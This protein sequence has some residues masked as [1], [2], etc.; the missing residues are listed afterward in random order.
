M[1]EWAGPLPR[2]KLVPK[3]VR[4]GAFWRFFKG[5]KHGQKHR[6]TD[7]MVQSLNAAYKSSAKIIQKI[8]GQTRERSHVASCLRHCTR[9]WHSQAKFQGHSITWRNYEVWGRIPLDNITT[10]VHD[11]RNS[12]GKLARIFDVQKIVDEFS[13]LSIR[14]KNQIFQVTMGLGIFSTLFNNSK[15]GITKTVN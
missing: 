1:V 3:M 2:K 15:Y 11:H 6:N 8:D 12:I 5:R 10:Q 4:L 13:C 7:F 14:K 9:Q